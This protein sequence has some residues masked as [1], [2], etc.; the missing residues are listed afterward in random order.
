M[1]ASYNNEMLHFLLDNISYVSKNNIKCLKYLNISIK[2][3]DLSSKQHNNKT[4]FDIAIK[5]KLTKT[6]NT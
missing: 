6:Q 1:M 5:V 3:I 2:I 4:Y